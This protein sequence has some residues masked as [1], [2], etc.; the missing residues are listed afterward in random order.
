MAHYSL[1]DTIYLFQSRGYIHKTKR[2]SAVY[3]LERINADHARSVEAQRLIRLLRL[4]TNIYNNVP[5]DVRN[6]VVAILRELQ[7]ANYHD[8]VAD[9]ITR[10]SQLNMQNPVPDPPAAARKIAGLLDCI[11][12]AYGFHQKEVLVVITS[13]C[14]T[15]DSIGFFEGKKAELSRNDEFKKLEQEITAA[16][17]KV[18][19]VHQESVKNL[20]QAQLKEVT[21]V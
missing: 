4:P 18:R 14:S 20:S 15:T 16:G 7:P 1:N 9:V 13:D 21:K 19:F 10:M 8:G 6:E 12:I 5:V 3:Y 11:A 2:Q 17:W